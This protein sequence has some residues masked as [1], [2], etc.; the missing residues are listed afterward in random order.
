MLQM[1][2]S[3]FWADA[4]G[5]SASFFCHFVS[6][7][8][9]CWIVF[10]HLVMNGMT[11]ISWRRLNLLLVPRAKWNGHVKNTIHFCI[12]VCRLIYVKFVS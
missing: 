2:G 1:L 10:E 8:F 11:H 9:S 12:H 3:L 4:D 6:M 5:S 7:L